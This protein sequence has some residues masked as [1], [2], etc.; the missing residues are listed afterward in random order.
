[1]TVSVRQLRHAL[2]LAE[3][4]SFT[5]AAQRSN[6]SQSA[7]SRSIE[8]LEEHLGVSLFHRDAGAVKPTVFGEAVL[9]SAA[10]VDRQFD[11]IQR[12]IDEIQG[13]V[14]GHLGVAMGVYPAE[15]TGHKALGEMSRRF[16]ELTV[17]VEV[18]N[19]QEVNKRVLSGQVELAYAVVN[20]ALE[21]SHLSVER[22]VAH[23]MAY[24]V[25][26]GHPLAN[27]QRVTEE[28]LNAYPLISIRIPSALAAEIHGKSTADPETGYLIPALEIDDFTLARGVVRSSDAIGVSTPMQIEQELNRR[29]FVL[30]RYPRPWIAPEY[31]FISKA[32]YLLSPAAEAFKSI[33]CEAETTAHEKNL[34]LMEHYLPRAIPA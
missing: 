9:T 14:R 26:P 7:L 19:W 12:R 3:T 18:C 8:K 17:R 31:G 16:P 15:I 30:L 22:V 20:Q 10:Q 29:E 23:E 32:G 13:L 24:Y 27:E 1:M 25:R 28:Q 6:L 11:A 33:V 34:Q 4:G 5:K 21:E 2:A